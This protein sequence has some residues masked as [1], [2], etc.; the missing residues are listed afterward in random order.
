MVKMK[1]ESLIYVLCIALIIAGVVVT[2][3]HTGNGYRFM[4]YGASTMA[5]FQSW[6]IYRLKNRIKELE[7]NQ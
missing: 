3:L 7:Q 2:I 5:A 4:F 6:H 1:Y